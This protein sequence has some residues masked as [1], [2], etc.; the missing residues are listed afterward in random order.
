LASW[1]EQQLPA[2]LVTVALEVLLALE[3]RRSGN[4]E[5]AADHDTSRLAL[6]VGIHG[7][8]D[9]FELHLRRSSAC[10]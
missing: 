3:H 2:K 1:L 8:E 9:S 10:G 7:V 5:D 4:V 6:A